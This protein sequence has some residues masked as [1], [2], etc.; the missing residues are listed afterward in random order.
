MRKQPP[1]SNEVLKRK[2]RNA[3]THRTDYLI[4]C[5]PV[6]FTLT[7]FVLAVIYGCY[8][9]VWNNH[10]LSSYSEVQEWQQKCISIT[11]MIDTL[12]DDKISKIVCMTLYH[13]RVVPDS[14]E[15]S[16]IHQFPSAPIY[17]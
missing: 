2:K 6:R 3:E 17:F 12:A 9:T 15:L 4:V 8:N 13:H 11:N 10:L 14:S 5:F 7:Q 1:V 16:D